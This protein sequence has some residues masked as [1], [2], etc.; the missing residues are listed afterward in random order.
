MAATADDALPIIQNA[1]QDQIYTAS[2][3]ARGSTW[4]ALGNVGYNLA[5]LYSLL[6]LLRG[7]R[8]YGGF[9][10]AEQI[11]SPAERGMLETALPVAPTR[12]EVRR[13]ARGLWTWT[14]HVRAEVER[15]LRQPLEVDVDESGLLLAVDRTYTEG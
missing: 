5:S 11:L 7:Y 12:D 14:L 1:I 4:S 9:R 3:N 15:V 10:Y 2:H 8:T 6:A 13:A